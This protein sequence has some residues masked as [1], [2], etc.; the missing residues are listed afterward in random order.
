MPQLKAD[1]FLYRALGLVIDA[2]PAEEIEAVMTAEAD[3][4]AQRQQ[5]GAGCLGCHGHVARAQGVDAKGQI[6]VARR[7]IDVGHR[8]GVNDHLRRESLNAR[9][10]C[11]EI[12]QIDFGYIIAQHGVLCQ[13]TPQLQADLAFGA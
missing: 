5:R 1:P 7:A 8:G 10:G 12:G 9:S 11:S 3:A 6:G 13:S 2:A 4:T